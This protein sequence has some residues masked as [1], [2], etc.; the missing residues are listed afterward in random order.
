MQAGRGPPARDATLLGK[1]AYLRIQ[2]MPR[3]SGWDRTLQ[4]AERA[5]NALQPYAGDLAG[6]TVLGMLTLL[7]AFA[8]AVGHK[9]GAARA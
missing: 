1:A 4:A 3:E 9:P 2:T 6:R 7:S 5:A 8:A